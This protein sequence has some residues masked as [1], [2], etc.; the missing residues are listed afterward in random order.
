MNEKLIKGLI[1]GAAFGASFCATVFV[2]D[3]LISRKIHKEF[4]AIIKEQEKEL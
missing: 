3:K 1:T 4:D 2:F